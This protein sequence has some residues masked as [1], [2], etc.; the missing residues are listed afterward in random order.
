MKLKKNIISLFNNKTDGSSALL[1]KLNQIIKKESGDLKY[2]SC[3][4]KESRRQFNDF[5]IIQNYLNEIEKELNNEDALSRIIEYYDNY[6]EKVNSKIFE[7]GKEYFLNISKVMTLS[8]SS[9]INSFLTHL[10]GVNNK[11][12]VIIT[13]SRPKNEGRELAKD[14][15]KNRIPVE[16]ISDFSAA[17]FIPSVDAVITGA[18]KI[19]SSGNV[20]NKTG[21]RTLAILCRYYK[22]PFYV[23][24]TK[25]KQ[26]NESKYSPR[27]SDPAEV[28]KYLDKNLRIR[29]YYFEEIERDLITR[30]IT[31]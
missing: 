2:I 13:E 16:F 12:E 4:I 5:S 27:E 21:S 30:I 22:K 9:T 19:L 14:I 29:N 28:W 24:T 11:L 25:D 23:I 26:S 7:N 1:G 18:D 8:N 3:I 6:S 10:H 31:D 15:L 20:V 17:S